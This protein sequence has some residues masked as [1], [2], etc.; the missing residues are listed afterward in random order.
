[1]VMSCIPTGC[2]APWLSV[3]STSKVFFAEFQW[4]SVP[5]REITTKV[6]C[7]QKSFT[8]RRATDTPTWR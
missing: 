3:T 6:P 7:L 4:E 2:H 8:F 1:M 5:S